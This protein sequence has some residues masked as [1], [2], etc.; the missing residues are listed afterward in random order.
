MSLSKFAEFYRVNDPDKFRL[1]D[2]NPADTNDLDIKKDEAKDLLKANLAFVR[3]CEFDSI[4]AAVTASGNNDRVVIMP[5]RYTE[6]DSRSAPR[7][8]GRVTRQD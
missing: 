3:R 5:G 1:K 6:P 2:W 7:V 8:V 4:Q